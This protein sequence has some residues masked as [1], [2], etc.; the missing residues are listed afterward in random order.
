[1]VKQLTAKLKKQNSTV[2]KF[3]TVQT[4]AKKMMER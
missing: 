4:E 2:A 3:A 1:M